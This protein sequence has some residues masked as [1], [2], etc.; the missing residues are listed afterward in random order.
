MGRQVDLDDIIDAREVAKMIGLS[1]RNSTYLYR[2]R[3]R[4]R[5]FPQ[6]IL[7]HGR[8][9]FWL[10]GDVTAWVETRRIKPTADDASDGSSSSS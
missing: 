9:L 4:D 7:E 1:H 6:P 8:C 10:R 3:Y 2:K 5:G